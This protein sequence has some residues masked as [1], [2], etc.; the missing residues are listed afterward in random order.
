MFCFSYLFIVED[1]IKYKLNTALIIRRWKNTC[2]LQ[3]T[4]RVEY[5]HQSLA[6]YPIACRSKLFSVYFG[7]HRGPISS[8]AFTSQGRLRPSPYCEQ[9]VRLAVCYW[10]APWHFCESTNRF[11]S[12]DFADRSRWWWLHHQHLRT[13]TTTRTRTQRTKTKEEPIFPLFHAVCSL[14]PTFVRTHRHMLLRS[15][16]LLRFGLLVVFFF[17]LFFDRRSGRRIRAGR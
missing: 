7:T 10:L 8:R 13:N 3:F 12:G 17:C 14:L 11:S 4:I 9:D 2:S 6:I 1:K 16:S 15:L 5:Y